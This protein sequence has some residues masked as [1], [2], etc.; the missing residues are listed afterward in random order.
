MLVLG[1]RRDVRRQGLELDGE[2]RDLDARA[3][4]VGV[5]LAERRR[6]GPRPRLRRVG[7]RRVLQREDAPHGLAHLRR[8]EGRV[9]QA[10]LRRVR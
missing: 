8:V 3:A 10:E 7:R 4:A 2:P 5:V 6:D 1:V 9:Q